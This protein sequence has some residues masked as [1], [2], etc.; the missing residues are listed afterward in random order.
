MVSAAKILSTNSSV[1]KK[2]NSGPVNPPEIIWGNSCLNKRRIRHMISIALTWL[3]LLC[4]YS[5][6]RLNNYLE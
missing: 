4:D 1:K 3:K 5:D 2:M 6:I